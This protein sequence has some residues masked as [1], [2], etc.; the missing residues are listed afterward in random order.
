[1][2]PIMSVDPQMGVG[3]LVPSFLAVLVGGVN[4]LL[5]AVL[6]SAVIGGS[7]TGFSAYI[8]QADAQILV[9]ILAMF[10]I[11]LFPDGLTGRKR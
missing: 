6:G 10:L 2:S 4:S 1:M 3:F 5:G 8:S 11:R 9:F 7:T